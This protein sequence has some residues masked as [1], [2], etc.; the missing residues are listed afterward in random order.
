MKKY[1]SFILAL[2]IFCALQA[3]ALADLGMSEFDNWNVVCG[4]SGWDFDEEMYDYENDGSVYTVHDHLEPGTKLSVH[5]FNESDNT[6]LLVA[7]DKN[8]KPKGNGFV[9]VTEKE[10]ETDFIDLNKT[11]PR[12]E[13]QKLGSEVKCVVSP[14]GGIV[15]RQGPAKT[16]PSYRNVPK[17]T[18]ITYQYTYSYGGYNWGYTTYKGQ[19]GW[20]CIDLTEEY[21][22][23]PEPEPE[24]VKEPE[25]EP[26][27]PS[28]PVPVTP[29]ADAEQPSAANE[30]EAV[31]LDAAVP[32]EEQ[33]EN[34]SGRM[35]NTSFTIL[36]CCICAAAIALAAMIILL[37]IKRRK[38][39]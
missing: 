13:G 19:T 30:T 14:E 26:D 2:I 28:E 29:D 35:S 3:P 7:D 34:E 17:G 21:V 36:I 15:L 8:Y 33:T 9:F 39:K 25:T 37:I 10:L 1:L 31:L 38:G 5:S 4:L 20:L 6:Y 27:A 23:T 12:E 18:Q 32:Q 24:P 11:V 22:E 16:F